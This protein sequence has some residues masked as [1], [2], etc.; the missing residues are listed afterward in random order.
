M[1]TATHR[2]MSEQEAKAAHLV[3]MD[4]VAKCIVDPVPLWLSEVLSDWSFDVRSQ[5]SIDQMR[6]MRSQMWG[7]LAEAG[8]LAIELQD[9]L[10]NAALAGFLVT[11]SKLESEEELKH[12]A[13]DSA[14]ET[15]L[16]KAPL[17]T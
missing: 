11:N 9:L 1:T 12:L 4:K 2:R 10:R 16:G 15:Q 3:K 14:P 8:S 6:P 17:V 13:A 5:D 7:S